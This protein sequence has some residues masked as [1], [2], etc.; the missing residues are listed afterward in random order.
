M[1]REKAR[2]QE[3]YFL[4]RLAI[5]TFGWLTDKYASRFKKLKY[6]LIS[7]NA[8]ILF[9]TYVSLMFF[10]SFIIFLFSLVAT[11]VFIIF[12]RIT[13]IALIAGLFTFP[14]VFTALTFFLLYVYPT[15]LAQK[16]KSDIESNL[17]FVIIH[18]SAIAGSGVPP[19][20][21][22]KV[23]SEFK[24]YG[25]ISKEAENVS[26][27]ISVFGLDE[28]TALKEVINRSPSPVFKDLLQG[29]LTTIQTGGNL[30]SYL[31]EEAEKA[32]FEYSLKRNKYS[33][34]LSVYADVYTALLIAAPLILISILAVLNLIGGTIFGLTIGSLINFG[35]ILLV[36]LNFV[37]L[38]FIHFTQPRL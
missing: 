12:L 28:I 32:L 27:N 36:V 31:K 37:F 11:I 33:Q 17:P 10:F 19:R 13:D 24:E 30:R 23:L 20:T 4:K 38:A 34:I 15:S 18:M 8:R 16:R 14:I 1:A 35:L 5:L 2:K 26:R 3:F 9:R 21:I 22:F 7:S 6:F 29:I 25:E